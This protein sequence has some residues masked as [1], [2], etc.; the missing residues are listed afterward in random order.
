MKFDKIDIIQFTHLLAKNAK[1]R[2]NGDRHLTDSEAL[3]IWV[4]CWK[5]GVNCGVLPAAI[6]CDAMA[7]LSYLWAG[8]A[9]QFTFDKGFK[10][11]HVTT[12]MNKIYAGISA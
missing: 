9:S 4:K 12:A 1:R 5:D 10:D 8:E 2:Y 3:S 11:S 6:K 7:C